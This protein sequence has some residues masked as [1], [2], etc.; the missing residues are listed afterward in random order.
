M[1]IIKK[2][3]EAMLSDSAQKAKGAAGAVRMKEFEGR[4]VVCP[5]C[6]A[7]FEVFAPHGSPKRM[8]ARCPSCGSLERHRLLWKYLNEKTGLNSRGKLRVLHFAPEKAFYERLASRTNLEY[9]PAD[10]CPDRYHNPAVPVH[11]VDITAIPFEDD[12]FDVIICCHVLEHIPDDALAMKELRRVLKRGGWAVLQVP[13]DYGR[14]KTYEDF[15]ITTPEGRKEAFG[16]RNHMRWYG[17]DYKM[18]LDAAG[19]NVTEDDYV[20]KLPEHDIF[21]FGLNANEFIYF[22]TKKE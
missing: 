5:I 2:L 21:R 3:L 10:L 8:N 14:E 18:R 7:E 1:K 6:Q 20:M 22:C 9:Y 19:F 12:F 17:R 13:L 4:G 15:S 11:K 16:Q